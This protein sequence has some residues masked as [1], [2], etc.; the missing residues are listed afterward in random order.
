[1]PVGIARSALLTPFRSGCNLARMATWRP[2]A[3]FAV[4]FSLLAL[5]G[6]PVASEAFA[7]RDP[8]ACCPESAPVESAPCQYVAPLACCAQLGIP[9]PAPA[10]GLT[11]SGLALALPG[12]A[13][14]APAPPAQVLAR[15]RNGH[16][17]PQ[18]D[19]IRTTVLRL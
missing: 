11:A 13:S 7:R 8:H 9:A 16:G 17:P 12:L 10:D 4:A 14:E 18:A 2:C 5:L 1:M 3:R 15:A 19:Q 6:A